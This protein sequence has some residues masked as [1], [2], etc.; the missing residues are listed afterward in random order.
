MGEGRNVY[1]ALVGKPEGKRPVERSRRGWE[2]G[3]KMNL[4]EIGLG[5]GWSGFTWFRMGIV[6]GLLLMR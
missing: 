3:I 2:F 6:G 5:G 4:R 1:R